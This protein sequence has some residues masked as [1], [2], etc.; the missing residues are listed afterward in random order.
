MGFIKPTEKCSSCGGYVAT[1]RKGNKSNFFVKQKTHKGRKEKRC[2]KCNKILM[3][4]EDTVF[5]TWE[6]KELEETSI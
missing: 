2:C 3:R 6:S 4:E 1:V 5:E